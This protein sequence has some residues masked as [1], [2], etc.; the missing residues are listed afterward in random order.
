PESVG[1]GFAPI[2]S[3][4]LMIKLV[5]IVLIFKPSISS[6]V[7]TFLLAVQYIKPSNQNLNGVKPFSSYFSASGPYNASLSFNTFLFTS[8]L[9]E[10]KNGIAMICDSVI[11]SPEKP[12]D[13]IAISI[14]PVCNDCK[15][16]MFVP[17]CPAVYISTVISP[18]DFSSMI[19]LNLLAY[20][21]C[22]S[23]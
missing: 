16:S 14:A 18:S 2:N 17:N 19:S 1:V 12:G 21:S 13:V 22:T 11:T 10:N 5:G 7:V 8:K 15:T 3:Y 23:P 6:G 9:S 4:D 20:K